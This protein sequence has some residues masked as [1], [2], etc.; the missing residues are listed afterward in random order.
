MAASSEDDEAAK[1]PPASRAWRLLPV[2]VVVLAMIVAYSLGW[3]RLL[4]LETLVRHRAELEAFVGANRPA[5]V[6]SFAGVY[7]AAVAMSFPGAALLTITGGVLFGAVIGSIAA[8]IG[9]TVGATLLFLIASSAFG[10]VL[11]RR[12]GKRATKVA[13]GFRADA[14]SYLLFL[15]LVPI[16][17]FWL[18]NLAAALVGV[19]IATFVSATAIGIVPGTV[20]YAVLGAG[21][22]SVIAAQEGAFRSCVAAGRP[23][24]RLDFDL[25]AAVTPQ[26]LGAL[27]A[28]GIVALI[29]VVLRRFRRGQPAPSADAPGG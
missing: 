14:F 15:R 18:V 6:L 4:S 28:L 24:C 9:A 20:A 26:L 5:A 10:S 27:V 25:S 12:A 1:G 11:A 21:L 8:V 22:D 13:E 16:F 7:V 17:P 19:K 29:P 3:H 2:G 23:D